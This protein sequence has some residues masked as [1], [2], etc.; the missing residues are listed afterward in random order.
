MMFGVGKTAT[1]ILN[2]A[3]TKRNGEYNNSVSKKEWCEGVKEF[4]I[5]VFSWAPLFEQD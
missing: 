4:G 3:V 2:K 5:K 1:S